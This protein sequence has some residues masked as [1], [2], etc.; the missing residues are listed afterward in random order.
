M[1]VHFGKVDHVD[2][3]FGRVRSSSVVGRRIDVHMW[4]EPQ[5]SERPRT[6]P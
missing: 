4:H 2:L 6:I 1:A 5:D 3:V